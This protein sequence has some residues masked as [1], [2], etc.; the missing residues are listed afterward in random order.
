MSLLSPQLIAFMSVI[1]HKTVHAAADALNITQTAVTQRIK[2]LELRLKTTLFIRSRR[3]MDLTT[4]GEALLRYCMAARDLEGATLAQINQ[5]GQL[6]E[7]TLSICSATSIMR[8]RVIPA[9]LQLIDEYPNLLFNF[10]I[11][12]LA[13]RQQILKRGESDFVIMSKQF[14]T[15][16]MSH[17]QLQPEHYVLVCS[18]QWKRRRL[19][20]IIKTE[21]II[22]FDAADEATISYLQEYDLL[23]RTNSSRY[24]VNHTEMIADLVCKGV[25]YTTL[26]REFVKPYV[27]A[28]DMIILNESKTFDVQPYLAWF[29]R[30]E[31][32]RYFQRLI[33]AIN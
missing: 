17:K 25:G 32:P 5:S 14:L 31:P 16:E 3:G 11:Q 29:S 27:D 20:D 22:D 21:R 15:D 12:D 2:N 24:F 7:V 8:S 13:D 18:S 30:P 33:D 19:D 26:T 10:K 6:S 23:D 1:K 9:S 4:E 28:G